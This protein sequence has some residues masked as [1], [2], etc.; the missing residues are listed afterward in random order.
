MGGMPPNRTIPA[1]GGSVRGGQAQAMPVQLMQALIGQTQG[2]QVPGVVGRGDAGQGGAGTPVNPAPTPQL[3]SM[4]AP[5]SAHPFETPMGL[6]SAVAAGK[7][8][9]T[10]AE[11]YARGKG[12]IR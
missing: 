1:Q 5:D 6:R 8:H 4:A 10:H 11:S 2:S 9:R 12:W 7:L 3:V